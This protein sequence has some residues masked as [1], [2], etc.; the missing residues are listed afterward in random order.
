[1][2][3]NYMPIYFVY[4]KSEQN[5]YQALY[6]EYMSRL[7]MTIITTIRPFKKNYNNNNK[8]YFNN[9]MNDDCRPYLTNDSL[10]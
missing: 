9:M 10:C 1:M 2:I 5:T 6:V 8:N 3:T 7:C 4:L